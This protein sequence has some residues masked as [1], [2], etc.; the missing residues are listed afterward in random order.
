M[1]SSA[2][3][4]NGSLTGTNTTANVAVIIPPITSQYLNLIKNSSFGAAIAYPEVAEMQARAIFEAAVEAE[5]R[6]GKAVGL[7][8]MVPLIATKAEFDLVKARI[9]ATAKSVM[10]ETGKKLDYQ[11]GTMIELPR[12]ALMAG[13]IASLSPLRVLATHMPPLRLFVGG[14]YTTIAAAEAALQRALP[15][16]ARRLNG[17]TTCIHGG[18]HPIDSPGIRVL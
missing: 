7:E 13:E 17:G 5:K 1:A 18:D 15:A 6:T 4:P 16:L 2:T 3:M 11:V 10:K 12:A 8:V 14:D 9:D